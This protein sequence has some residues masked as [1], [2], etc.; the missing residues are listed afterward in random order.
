MKL[1]IAAFVIVAG[2]KDKPVPPGS[3]SGSAAGAVVPSAEVERV[4][5]IKA[6]LIGTDP[7][8]LAFETKPIMGMTLPELEATYGKYGLKM[9]SDHDKLPAYFTIPGGGNFP[10]ASRR[11]K[12]LEVHVEWTGDRVTS[13]WVGTGVG[14]RQEVVDALTAVRGPGQP[15]GSLEQNGVIFGKPPGPETV[16]Y[17]FVGGGYLRIEVRPYTGKLEE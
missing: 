14:Y 17:T 1:A 15:A 6:D 3:G 10:N 16:V 4:K 8:K 2:C 7:N 5:S 13:Y 12:N 11:D 9:V